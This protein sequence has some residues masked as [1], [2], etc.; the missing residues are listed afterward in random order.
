MTGRAG[1]LLRLA[2]TTTLIALP[3][4]VGAP[5]ATAVTP[6]AV[7]PALLPA[8]A[9]AMPAQPTAQR[10]VCATPTFDPDRAAAPGQLDGLDLA[11]VWSLSRGAGQRIAVI[12][13]GVSPH[14]RLP[15]LVGGGDYVSGGDGTQDCDGHGTVAAGIIA[16]APD[17]ASDQFSGVAPGATVIAIRQSSSRFAPLHAGSAAAVGDVETLAKAVRT[18]ADLGASVIN[19]SSVACE[20]VTAGID[21]RA[22]GAAL[23][24]AV[25]VKNAVVVAAAG[26]AG[27]GEP[28]PTQD[29]GAG[30]N[31]VTVAVS[32][33][34]YDDLVL[35]V[36][37]VD[38][39]GAPSAFTL[40]G[41]WVD[42]AAP[43][44]GVLSL[45]PV[46]DAMVNSTGAT[47][48]ARPLY[49]TSY[50]APVVS[51]LVALVRS[52]F[53]AWA[54]RQVMERIRATA[55]HPPGGRNNAVGNGVVDPLAALSTVA[56]PPAVVS[57]S[58]T[59]AAQADRLVSPGSQPPGRRTALGGTAGLFAALLLAVTARSMR[60]RSAPRRD[61]V[62][63]DQRVLPA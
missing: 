6:P 46:G 40:A 52:R 21:D 26:N 41:P 63:G 14:R 60:M 2:G 59:G 51:G 13:T 24:Y 3:Q 8:P 30:W 20:P 27:D 16:A 19:I 9:A 33:A 29:A 53:P 50:A 25:E 18:A 36:G 62:A 34:W 12:D 17:P 11:A 61:H 35:T 57:D 49:G 44:E 7:D 23:A 45:G 54:P 4:C 56:P 28:C 42:V 5:T 10:L 47:D 32:P 58:G 37:S 22:L 31:D 38:A 48:G 39:Q 43:G 1:R 55:H 15:A